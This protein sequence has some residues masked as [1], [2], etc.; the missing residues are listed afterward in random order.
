MGLNPSPTDF[1]VDGGRLE[2]D[3]T[4]LTFGAGGNIQGTVTLNGGDGNL[5]GGFP[6]ANGGSLTVHTAGDIS[7][8]S[9][10]EA[11]TGHEDADCSAHRH[12]RHS[13]TIRAAGA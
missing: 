11:T 1:A 6:A 5:G 3:P 13:Q 8:S 4:S 2:L 7:V 10:I 12:R 9:D